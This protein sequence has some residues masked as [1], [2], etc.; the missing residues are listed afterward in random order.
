VTL[1]TQKL[2]AL[3]FHNNYFCV[4]IFFE[5]L[6]PSYLI[7]KMLIKRNKKNF[8]TFQSVIK[9][10]RLDRLSLWTTKKSRIIFPKAMSDN[11]LVMSVSHNNERQAPF[12]SP[13]FSNKFQCLRLRIKYFLLLNLWGKSRL[14]LYLKIPFNISIV[15]IIYIILWFPIHVHFDNS[16]LSKTQFNHSYYSGQPLFTIYV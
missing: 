10:V 12:I 11:I 9:L 2:F 15:L 16:Y 1:H 13:T 3:N 5:A 6:K 14:W 4:K 8:K 7:A